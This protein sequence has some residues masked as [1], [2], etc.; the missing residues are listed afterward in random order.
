MVTCVWVLAEELKTD[1]P[2]LDDSF[3][4]ILLWAILANRK[5]L[6]NIYWLNGKNQLSESNNY[7][8][9]NAN[10]IGY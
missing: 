5:E 2:S 8:L 1:G 3:S 9:T 6:A 7:A 4:D 10:I